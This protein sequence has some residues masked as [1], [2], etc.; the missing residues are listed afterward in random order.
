VSKM[1]LNNKREIGKR[2]PVAK[3]QTVPIHRDGHI[4]RAETEADSLVR[5][6]DLLD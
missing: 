5:V 4:Q 3:T 2:L 1:C 6:E